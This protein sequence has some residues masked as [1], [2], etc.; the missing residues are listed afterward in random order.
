MLLDAGLEI[1][2]F[3]I[4]IWKSIEITHATNLKFFKWP[5]RITQLVPNGYQEGKVIFNLNLHLAFRLI[6]IIHCVLHIG[7]E[8]MKHIEDS[9]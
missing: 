4:L 1:N 7:Q 3:A 5:S 2:S 9:L 6:L 8:K